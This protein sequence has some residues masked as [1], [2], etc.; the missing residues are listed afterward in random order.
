[1]YNLREAKNH[2][3]ERNFSENDNTSKAILEWL[4]SKVKEFLDL[5]L[6][7]ISASDTLGGWKTS[8]HMLSHAKSHTFYIMLDNVSML[9]QIKKFLK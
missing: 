4:N 5:K 3:N 2:A 1:M 7:L 9:V 8:K 6:L